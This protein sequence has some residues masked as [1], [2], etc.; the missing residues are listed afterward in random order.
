MSHTKL[1]NEWIYYNTVGP[2]ERQY[3]TLRHR[4]LNNYPTYIPKS[5]LCDKV[6]QKSLT[7]S[8]KDDGEENCVY[9]NYLSYSEVTKKE[10]DREM[11]VYWENRSRFN[12]PK[13]RFITLSCEDDEEEDVINGDSLP[14]PRV[15]K[16]Q[17]DQEMVEY[18]GKLKT[19]NKDNVNEV[20]DNNISYL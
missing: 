15:T 18:W 3:V 17:L 12:S 8:S 2:A 6:I 4:F 16:E 14:Y 13:P 10:L 5:L 11:V 1:E 7:V 20:D 19:I 9:D